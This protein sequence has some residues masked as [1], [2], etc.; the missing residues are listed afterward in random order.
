VARRPQVAPS[1]RAADTGVAVSDENVEIVRRGIEAF[2]ARDVDD[3]VSLP[4]RTANG[5]HSGR[6]SRASSI[7]DTRASDNTSTT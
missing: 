6:S 4:T 2:N 1:A 3:L 7:D 5:F